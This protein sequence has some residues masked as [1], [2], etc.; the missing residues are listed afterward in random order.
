MSVKVTEIWRYPVK[1]M[2]GERLEHCH[3]GSLGRHA[4]IMLEVLAPLR[5]LGRHLCRLD[6]CVLAHCDTRCG[7]E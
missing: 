3:L 6:R 7:I 4:P 1:S 2:G 5:L